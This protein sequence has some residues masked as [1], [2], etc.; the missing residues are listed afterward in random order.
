MD[1]HEDSI[2][3]SCFDFPWQGSPGYQTDWIDIPA[4]RHDQGYSLSFADGHAEHWK[5]A[6]PK[7]VT[8]AAGGLQPVAPGE[9]GDYQRMATGIR[10]TGN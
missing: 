4:N 7:I 2:S 9:R 8:A 6:Y 5:W 10:R 3:D 1:V